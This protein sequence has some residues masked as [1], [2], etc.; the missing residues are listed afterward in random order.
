MEHTGLSPAVWATGIRTGDTCKSAQKCA[1]T[2]FEPETTSKIFWRDPDS[3]LR[4]MQKVVWPGFELVASR[5]ASY[6]A[7]HA[8]GLHCWVYHITKLGCGTAVEHVVDQ[9]RGSALFHGCSTAVPRLFHESPLYSRGTSWTVLTRG[10][11][12]ERRGLKTPRARGACAA[13]IGHARA[14]VGVAKRERPRR[15]WSAYLSLIH[16]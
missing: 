10:T 5:K 12:V 8:R 6:M 4:K 2:G 9:G 15:A 11:A 14:H 16:I 7:D 1:Q 13:G 3:N